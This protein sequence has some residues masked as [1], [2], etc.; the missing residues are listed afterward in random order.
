MW[1]GSWSIDQAVLHRI[2]VN[3]LNVPDEVTLVLDLMLPKAA[4]PNSLLTSIRMTGRY[5]A[6]EFIRTIPAK[7]AFDLPPSI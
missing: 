1:P 5:V 7:V 4:L 6:P 3:I 2:V